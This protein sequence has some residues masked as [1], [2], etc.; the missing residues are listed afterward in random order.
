MIIWLIPL[1]ASHFVYSYKS[2]HNIY[3]QTLMK[4]GHTAGLQQPCVLAG[5]KI[6]YC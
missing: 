4:Y 5:K 6:I 2:L 1:W 3:Y